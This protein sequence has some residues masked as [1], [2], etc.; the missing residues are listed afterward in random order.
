MTRPH[1]SDQE[2]HLWL[3]TDK[4]DPRA[5]ALVDGV[6]TNGRPHYSRQKPGSR[7]FTRN[8]Q[9]LVFIT[10]DGLAVWVTFRPTPGKAAR[11]DGLDAWEC[12]LFRN[13]GPVRSSAL[14][15]EAVTLSLALWA[16][17]PRDGF[18]T[19][20]KPECVRSNIPGYC[21]RRAGWVRWGAAADG[22]PRLRAPKPHSTRAWHEWEFAGDRG[23]RLRQILEANP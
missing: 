12:V 13:E 14:I 5:L 15:R 11:P 19:F 21:F 22:K 7:Q 6:T 16:P 9:N 4:G 8:G 1:P 20:I 10:A 23:G 18:I 17:W 2:A 3:I